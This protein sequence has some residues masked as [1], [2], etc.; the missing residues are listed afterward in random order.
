[1]IGGGVSWRN[2]NV[3]RLVADLGLEKRIRFTGY[4][5]PLDLPVLY[6]LATTF[7]YPSFYE[8]FGLPVLEAMGCGV[9]VVT[10]NVSSLP[11]IAEDAA[12]YVNPHSVDELANAISQ[13]LSDDGLR[14]NCTTKG[15][16]RVKSFTWERCAMETLKVFHEVFDGKTLSSR[17]QQG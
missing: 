12:V 9:P 4:I 15:R 8:G 5:E 6:N 7:V 3:S 2:E 14:K 11:E 16:E 17:Q 1:V 10:S 13:M